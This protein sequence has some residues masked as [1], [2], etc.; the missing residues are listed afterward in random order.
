[1]EQ[2]TMIVEATFARGGRKSKFNRLWLGE[3][4]VPV[5]GRTIAQCLAK[6]LRQGWNITDTRA[7]ADQRGIVCEYDFQRPQSPVDEIALAE[8]KEQRFL[9]VIEAE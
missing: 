6:M 7:T 1:M 8:L 3:E 9:A 2:I 5:D 4:E